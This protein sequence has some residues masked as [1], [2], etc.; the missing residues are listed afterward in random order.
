MRKIE[1]YKVSLL[2]RTKRFGIAVIKIS[3]QL[4]KNPAG[5]TVAD[6]VVRSSTSIGANLIEAQEAV[7][8]K[9]FLYKIN[10]S[11]KEA[12]ETKY[13]LEIIKESSL[14]KS[15]DITPLLQE[16]NEIVKILIATLKKLKS[17]LQ[18]DN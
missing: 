5:F 14:L 1:N 13:W 7:S 15:E 6:Q 17:N 10:H 9:D 3:S 2:E 12:K 4:P 18:F 16:N 11:L 8:K